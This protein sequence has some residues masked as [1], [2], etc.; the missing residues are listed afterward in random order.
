MFDIIIE[1]GQVV[2]GTGKVSQ[3]ADIGIKADKIAAIGDLAHQTA[4]RRL[5]AS[6]MVVSPGFIDIHTHSELEFLADGRAMSAL[7]Q[8]VTTHVTGNCGMSV[9]PISKESREQVQL[10]MAADSYGIEWRWDSL[11]EWLRLLRSL[12]IA[13]NVA[14][15]V[16]HGTI[17][18][19]AMGF[20]DRPPSAKELEDMKGL[21]RQSMEEGAF[22]LSTGLVYPPG[23]YSDTTELIELAKVVAEY[24]GLYTSH[25]RGEAGTLLDA[26]NEALTIGTE[27]GA[28]VEISHHKAAGR[29][30]WGKVA[31]SYALIE[32]AAKDHDVTFDIYPYQAGNAALGQL[33]PPWSLAGGTSKLLERLRDKEERRRIY[34]DII[35][36]CPNWANYFPIDWQDI[37]I[38]SLVSCD[39]QWM[40]G[41]SV[42][43][44]ATQLNQDP[45]ELVMDLVYSEA[46]QVSMVNFVISPEDIEFLLP[47]PL[48]MIGSDGRAVSPD[49]PT[50]LGHP[51]PRYYG[52][53]PRILARYVRDKG[54]LTLEAAI[55]KMTGMPAAKLR[56]HRRGLIKPGYYADVTVFSSDKV[57]DRATFA[58]PCQLAT[59]VEWVLV[60]GN[61]AL[62]RG[63]QASTR[64]GRILS[65]AHII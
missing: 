22:G 59:G 54:I 64:A 25:I 33:L 23:M 36:G 52:T 21:L 47:K 12:P 45:V 30:N 61:I 43:E 28:R 40:T 38:S 7:Y 50:G 3:R 9:A 48:A 31:E 42:E 58:D 41:L 13:I 60:N 8:G 5:D 11:G 4:N 63:K 29:L 2:D 35:H 14:P 32:A 20:D 24:N 51:H 34:H 49:G 10:G 55:H 53:F 15:L 6:G 1:E 56:L 57:Q 19:T 16:G 46:N 17:R 44:I 37:R 62:D 26:I 18:A 65:P 39:K 27:S